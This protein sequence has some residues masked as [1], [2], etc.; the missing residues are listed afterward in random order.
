MNLLIYLNNKLQQIVNEYFKIKYY[1][2]WEDK[3]EKPWLNIQ[4]LDRMW[5][6]IQLM[7]KETGQDKKMIFTMN[8]H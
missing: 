2:R 6:I 3:L 8:K 7:K 1:N 4:M 5:L